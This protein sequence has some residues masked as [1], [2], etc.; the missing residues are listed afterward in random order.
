MTAND[1]KN[2]LLH[3]NKLVDHYNN[4]CHRSIG[5]KSINGDYSALTEKIVTNV[6]APK[7]KVSDRIIITKYKNIFSNGYTENWSRQIFII[8]YLS[9][10]IP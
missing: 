2:Y 4:T 6:K 1:S 3:L 5:N 8:N 9:K 10:T 7:F